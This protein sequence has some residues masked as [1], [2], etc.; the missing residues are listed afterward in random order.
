MAPRAGEVFQPATQ[1]QSI[2]QESV[3][4]PKNCISIQH[5]Q[6]RRFFKSEKVQTALTFER[7]TR[8]REENRRAPG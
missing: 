7:E 3:S 8:G 4:H 2:A 1:A 6:R 5:L